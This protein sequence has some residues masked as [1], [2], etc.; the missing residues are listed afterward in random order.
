MLRGVIKTTLS[1]LNGRRGRAAANVLLIS[2]V[3]ALVWSAVVNALVAVPV[4]ALLMRMGTNVKILGGSCSIIG[5][6][7]TGGDG[8][9]V[10][11]LPDL[12]AP[13]RRLTRRLSFRH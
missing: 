13:T 2:P 9:R 3:K 7:A 11:C 10:D 12:T 5:W 8:Y 6:L 1:A 4:M